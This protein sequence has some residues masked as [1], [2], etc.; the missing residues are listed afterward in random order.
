MRIEEIRE[1]VKMLEQSTLNTL[2]FHEGES[3]IR[4]EKGTAPSGKSVKRAER[5]EE[6][7]SEKNVETK[8]E[9]IVVAKP[10]RDDKNAVKCP[11]VGVFYAAPSPDD[12]AFVSV[13]TQVKKGDVLC[14]VEAMKLMNEIVAER[15]GVISEICVENGEVVEYGQPLFYYE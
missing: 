13:G 8:A 2:E 15:D 1:L 4:L 14:I 5:V 9:P 11:L 6:M 3:S 12:E 10:A 7:I